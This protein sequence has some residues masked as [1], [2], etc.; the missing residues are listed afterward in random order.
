MKKLLASAVSGAAVL[1]AIFG[2]GTANGVNEFAGQ[3]Y[4]KAASVIKNN[5]LTVVVGSRVGS[6]LPT[7]KCLVTGSRDTSVGGSRKIVLY[8][9]CNDASALEGHPG[10]SVVTPQ[11]KKVQQIIATRKFVNENFAKATAEGSEPFCEKNT[12]SCVNFCVREGAG[13]SEELMQYLGL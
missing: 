12:Q 6:Y 9:N 5:G 4:E 1:A 3:T 8:L 2:A 11:G 7:E 10:N 13:C